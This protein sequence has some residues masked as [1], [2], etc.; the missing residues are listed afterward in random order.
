MA[1]FQRERELLEKLLLA[2]PESLSENGK[3]LA[4][5]DICSMGAL[6]KVF[7]DNGLKY[8]LFKTYR[9]GIETVVVSKSELLKLDASSFAVTSDKLNCDYLSE[10]LGLK[11][12]TLKKHS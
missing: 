4:Y 11:K 8:D 3:F 2:L 6:K 5:S 9:N 12:K 7:D 1:Q 10:Y